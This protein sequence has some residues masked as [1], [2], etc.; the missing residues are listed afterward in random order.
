MERRKDLSVEL[1]VENLKDL[2]IPE[3]EDHEDKWVELM[4]R[5][6][7]IVVHNYGRGKENLSNTKVGRLATASDEAFVWWVLSQYKEEWT[8]D[9]PKEKEKKRGRQPMEDD[10]EDE[11]ENQGGGKKKKLSKV[12]GK[13]Q[14]SRE[15]FGEYKEMV[16][17]VNKYRVEESYKEKRDSL[18]DKLRRSYGEWAKG[19]TVSVR[20]HLKQKRALDDVLPLYG[21]SELLFGEVEGVEV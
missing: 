9:I 8:E 7:P 6:L 10:D 21:D 5:Y 20:V 1:N 19:D 14:K 12:K 2:V 18:E 15:G 11:E 17:K 4:M 16:D 13:R 3:D